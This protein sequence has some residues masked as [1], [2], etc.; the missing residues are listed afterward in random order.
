MHVRVCRDCGEEYR[1]DAPLT[2]CADCGGLI[3][4]RDASETPS[5]GASA[6]D[7]PSD[8]RLAASDA[9]SIAT[10]AEALRAATVPFLL[11][12]YGTGLELRVAEDDYERAQS[13]A[14][15]A[16]TY[17]SA[18]R[19]VDDSEEEDASTGVTERAA[20][21]FDRERG[22]ARCPA[23]DSET[24][25]GA[26]ECPECGLGLGGPEADCPGCGARI[27]TGVEHCPE[28]GLRF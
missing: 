25:P 11:R 7:A 28:C 13:V 2:E 21:G 16:S 6:P 15:D 20:D 24:P 27:A 19:T 17:A 8:R 3:E 14:E 26:A 10:L 18:K 23:C 1:L 12:P 22:Y 5:T 9:G 4:S